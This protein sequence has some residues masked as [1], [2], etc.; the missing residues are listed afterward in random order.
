[1]YS[2]CNK[3]DLMAHIF[4]VWSIIKSSTNEDYQ[5]EFVYQPHP[6]QILAI[7]LLLGL[8]SPKKSGQQKV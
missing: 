7:F 8:D 3:E 2:N 5:I 1:V 6:A 4:A